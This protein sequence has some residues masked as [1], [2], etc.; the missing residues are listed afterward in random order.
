[1]DGLLERLVTQSQSGGGGE[2]GATETLVM[3]KSVVK[4]NVHS[5]LKIVKAANAPN[6]A[7][8][9]AVSDMTEASMTLKRT[10]IKVRSVFNPP[11][12]AGS[13]MDSPATMRFNKLK[14]Q[15]AAKKGATALASS[16]A[17]APPIRVPQKKLPEEP[18][19]KF[20]LDQRQNRQSRSMLDATL[21]MLGA[22]PDAQTLLLMKQLDS[23]CRWLEDE[24]YRSNEVRVILHI[25]AAQNLSP[26]DPN[27]LSDPYCIIPSLKTAQGAE[28]KTKV[29][30]ENLDPVWEERF[31]VELFSRSWGFRIELMD[32]DDPVTSKPLGF[33]DLRAADWVL[34]TR[35][36]KRIWI[37]VEN[38]NGRIYIGMKGAA[39]LGLSRVEGD[40]YLCACC[41]I[42]DIPDLWP[43][44]TCQQPTCALCIGAFRCDT[45]REDIC[46]R[47][48]T[49]VEA[50]LLAAEADV[51]VAAPQATEIA[52]AEKQ[53][54]EMTPE[55]WVGAPHYKWPTWDSTALGAKGLNPP[56]TVPKHYGSEYG[57]VS[58]PS[59]KSVDM[60]M[61]DPM[62][63]YPH[64]TNH[65]IRSEHGIFVGTQTSDNTPVVIVV[66]KLSHAGSKT[67]Q[68]LL[69]LVYAPD[70]TV[71][72]RLVVDMA[73]LRPLATSSSGF[74]GVGG[75]DRK[76]STSERSS[77]VTTASATQDD[78]RSY[79]VKRFPEL[80]LRR[81][82]VSFLSEVSA[83][84]LEYE[85][86]HT[87]QKR[88]IGVLHVPA[89]LRSENDVFKSTGSADLY[90]FMDMLAERIRLEGWSK[91]AG[92]LNTKNN[93][94]GSE[95]Y[96]TEHL[97]FS[98]MFHVTS[99]LEDDG[100]EQQL[101]RKRYIGNDLVVFVFLEG[102]EPFD[103]L[104]VTSQMC[105]TFI[106]VRKTGSKPTKY[107][108]A[109]V[110]K[111]SVPEY[112][113]LVPSPNEFAKGKDL[114]DFLLAK[115][116]NGNRAVFQAK[117]FL[118]KTK[119]TRKDLLARMIKD[120]N[121]ENV[122]SG[123]PEIFVNQ[124]LPA[125]S[126]CAENVQL[127]AVADFIAEDGSFLSLRTGDI[128]TAVTSNPSD[129]HWIG[130]HS[131][132]VGRYP[133][134]IVELASKKRTKPM[135]RREPTQIKNL[136]SRGGTRSLFQLRIVQGR[137]MS[138]CDPWGTSDPYCTVA[139]MATVDGR[140]IKTK[141]H[142]RTLCPEWNQTF[143]FASP[144]PFSFRVEV[145][146][147]DLV[148]SD[149]SMGFVDILSKEWDLKVGE[150][151]IR[152]LPVCE[153]D[154]EIQLAIM[155]INSG[156]ERRGGVS[157]RGK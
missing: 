153:G 96:Y 105:H 107:S 12:A 8:D 51:M 131:G 102:D 144:E 97:D 119:R 82:P 147:K 48:K 75:S 93:T 2:G 19:S 79:L 60:V 136:P 50:D 6:A 111:P 118:Q 123:S 39:H 95:S 59:L 29:Q 52:A 70:G 20:V 58:N 55:E 9:T 116:L 76:G 126:L 121:D 139:G 135:L 73:A 36:E 157:P 155:Q 23:K 7:I 14:K 49:K 125:I 22:E 148:G 101:A 46:K 68:T 151:T 17:A 74:L 152:W 81:I 100:S 30:H 18:R 31:E 27:G 13:G 103:P 1:M 83:K 64:Y 63:T 122:L 98:I 38:G 11:A 28:I 69:A 110:S 137:N 10:F 142:S 138:I 140:P 53:A 108:V 42:D 86:N 113:P 156:A 129:V 128:V 117:T 114:R 47:R 149:D 112:S 15:V 35:R 80:V 72:K 37:P 5:V 16:P 34:S 3:C 56:I 146:D 132:V 99:L 134:D 41:G 91:Y 4:K 106:V 115:A 43:C 130:I 127:R 78:L 124:D 133:R 24:L 26:V 84:M 92:G 87:D 71:R 45:C 33:V 150:D 40:Q 90:E 141:V 44:T 77:S 143:D 62:E 85:R 25:I 94:T 57:V 66:E 120:L 65:M 104:M 89:G 61:L 88:R 21:P 154:G 67:E 32:Y 145:W 54:T 109:V